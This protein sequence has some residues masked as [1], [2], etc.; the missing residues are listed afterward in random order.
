MPKFTVT[1]KI[2][3]DAPLDQVYAE[4]RNFREWP[5]WSPRVIAEP[6]CLLKFREDGKAY[7]WDGKIIGSGAMEITGEDGNSWISYDLNF[8]KPWKSQADVRMDFQEREEGVEVTWSM[9]SSL[10]FYLFF[11]KKL[12]VGLMGMDYERGLKMLKEHVETGNVSSKLEIVGPD[13]IGS[14]RYIGIKR[15][16]PVAELGERMGADFERIADY[17][18]QIGLDVIGPGFSI[19]HKWDIGNKV[20]GYTA[21]LPVKSP[22][23]SLPDDLLTG[24]RPR[25]SVYGIRHYGSFDHL[26][27]AWSAGI[28]HGRAKE[29]RQTRKHYP[30]EIY[31]SMPGENEEP[32][33]LV[34]FP[35]KG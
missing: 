24:R 23:A 11:M 7:S 10:P 12:M 9:K 33:T 26:G 17:L 25:L 16:C 13:S 5:K 1:E 2:L 22:P 31:E 6:E 15:E 27:N 19:Y 20:A 34:C 8:Y 28:F 30:I 14:C 21:A 35:T 3:I 4:V 18:N 29:F 32:V